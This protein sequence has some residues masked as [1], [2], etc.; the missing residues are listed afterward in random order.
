MNPKEA[1]ASL[2]KQGWTETDIA[3]AVG[4]SQPTINRIKGNAKPLFDLGIA[5]VNLASANKPKK[6][7]SRTA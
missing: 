2:Q 7:K 5:L 6:A 4:T 1:I 3:V